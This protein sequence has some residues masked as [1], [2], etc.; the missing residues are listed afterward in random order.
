[1]SLCIHD[2]E[3]INFRMCTYIIFTIKF[4]IIIEGISMA[5]IVEGILLGV[6]KFVMHD[7][8]KK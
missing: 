1:M 3:N 4:I 6:G 7:A 8:K 5:I 2:K